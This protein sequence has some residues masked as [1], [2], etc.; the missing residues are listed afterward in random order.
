MLWA[1]AQ[2]QNNAE[3]QEKPITP[4]R[5]S[6][7]LAGHRGQST[8]YI[9]GTKTELADFVAYFPYYS[10][11][12]CSS[13]NETQCWHVP[14]GGLLMLFALE[15]EWNGVLTLRTLDTFVQL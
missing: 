6:A 15:G 14:P 9:C 2:V 13:P 10:I 12:Y 11:S 5:S 7:P 1:E 8:V 4:A 3:P